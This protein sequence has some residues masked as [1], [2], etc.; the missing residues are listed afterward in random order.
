MVTKRRSVI[1]DNEAKFQLHLAYNYIREDSF[2]NAEKFRNKILASI[3]ELIKN[4][5]K[6][7]PDKYRINNDGS[8]RAYELL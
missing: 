4:P 7:P 6:Y 8:Y 1:I 5:E 2:Q 3:K